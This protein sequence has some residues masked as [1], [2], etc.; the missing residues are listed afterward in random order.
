MAEENPERNVRW[1]LG[2]RRSEAETTGGLT[3]STLFGEWAAVA[4]AKQCQSAHVG[5]TRDR[6]W[7]DIDGWKEG[8]QKS[9]FILKKHVGFLG[10]IGFYC[11]F[12]ILLHL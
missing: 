8:W 11:F 1:A 6:S 7:E 9:G 5:G 3:F 12:F 10:F 4:A 2:I